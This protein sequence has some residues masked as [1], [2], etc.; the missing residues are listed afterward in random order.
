MSTPSH[1]RRNHRPTAGPTGPAP[2]TRLLPVT[3]FA[4]STR[5]A[6]RGAATCCPT[7]VTERL[8]LDG[9]VVR[10]TWHLPYCTSSPAR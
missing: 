5:R 3:V 1:R 10:T 7:T 6:A 2:S 9:C 8:T 4:A